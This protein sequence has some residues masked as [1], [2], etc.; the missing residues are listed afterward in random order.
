MASASSNRYDDQDQAEAWVA[1]LHAP[2]SD[3]QDR[4]AF[5]RWLTAAPANTPATRIAEGAS[6]TL[7]S[8]RTETQ[9]SEAP[10]R[11]AP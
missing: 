3:T 6:S 7:S 5:E 11:S 1:R 10:K 9:P 2:D 4:E 8:N